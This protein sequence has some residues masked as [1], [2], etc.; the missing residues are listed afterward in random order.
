MLFVNV[1]ASATSCANRFSQYLYM[2]SGTDFTTL[3]TLSVPCGQRIYY[4][5]VL[6]SFIACLDSDANV[7]DSKLDSC[8]TN[9][10][11]GNIASEWD[12]WFCE[13]CRAIYRLMKCIT[14][15]RV[16][17]GSFISFSAFSIYLIYFAHIYTTFSLTYTESYSLMLF[18]LF[19][20]FSS[21]WVALSFLIV[22]VA[23]EEPH[24]VLRV[25]SMPS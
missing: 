22:V 16:S 1:W 14:P 17:S 18:L 11:K 4:V 21:T 7:V 23:A 19:A 8:L 9:V 3:S 5:I 25:G 2:N 20:S 10:A 12:C 13:A 6:A 15:K 24:V